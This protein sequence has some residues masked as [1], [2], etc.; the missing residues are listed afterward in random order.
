MRSDPAA[1]ILIL[2][3]TGYKFLED[4]LE[5]EIRPTHALAKCFFHML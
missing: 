4:D 5:L 3:F 1:K 2:G